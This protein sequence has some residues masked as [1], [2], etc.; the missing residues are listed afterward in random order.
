MGSD[1]K[2]AAIR[3]A[4]ASPFEP[5]SGTFRQMPAGSREDQL[6]PTDPSVRQPTAARPNA[7]HAA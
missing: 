4:L 6:L 7:S 3:S 2:K 5:P 1:R